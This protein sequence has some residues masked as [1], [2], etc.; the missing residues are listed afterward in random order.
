MLSGLHGLREGRKTSYD[1]LRAY[2]SVAV[3]EKGVGGST[4]AGGCKLSL[5]VWAVGPGR[6]SI[7][8]PRGKEKAPRNGGAEVK[9]EI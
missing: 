4:M 2:G 7:G 3:H 8:C 5:S 9:R 1:V 6:G